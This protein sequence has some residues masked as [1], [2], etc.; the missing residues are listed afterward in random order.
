MNKLEI[1]DIVIKAI[2]KGLSALGESPKQAVWYC[3]EKDFKLD[4]T[5]VP[6]NLKAFEETLKKFFGLGYGFLDALFRVNLQQATGENFEGYKTFADC[7]Q[8]LRVKA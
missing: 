6:E 8:A 1:D 3:L 5:K 7:V 2:D 4:R